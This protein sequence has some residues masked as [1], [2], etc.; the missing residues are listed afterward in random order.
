MTTKVAT[1]VPPHGQAA[2]FSLKV[3]VDSALAKTSKDLYIPAELVD[4]DVIITETKHKI[5][6]LQEYKR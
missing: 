1:L 4:D 2:A 5:L 3:K 6:I